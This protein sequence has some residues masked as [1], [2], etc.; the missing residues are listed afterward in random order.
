MVAALREELQDQK[1]NQPTNSLDH[2][3][4]DIDFQPVAL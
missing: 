1:T 3:F 2:N 4:L